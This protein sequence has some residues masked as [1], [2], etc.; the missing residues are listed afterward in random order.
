MSTNFNA[1]TDY[2]TLLECDPD[3]SRDELDI[4]YRN[5]TI[6]YSPG[7]NPGNEAEAQRVFQLIEHA[8]SVLSDERKRSTYNNNRRNNIRDEINDSSNYTRDNTRSYT[9]QNQEENNDFKIYY[10]II[11]A[12][13]IAI[14]I[15]LITRKS[16]N[17]IKDITL[18]NWIDEIDKRGP[19]AIYVVYFCKPHKKLI[20]SYLESD[21]MKNI[22]KVA[23]I[24]ASKGIK[25]GAI[26]R[27]KYAKITEKYTYTQEDT[28]VIFH[29][30]GEYVYDGDY[31][32]S[33]LCDAINEYIPDFSKAADETWN[34]YQN[35]AILFND[36][37]IVP[38][39]WKL[40]SSAFSNSK[41]MIGFTSEQSIIDFYHIQKLPTILI[42][43]KNSMYIYTGEFKYNTIKET[44]SNLY[45]DKKSKNVQLLI[46]QNNGF[47]KITSLKM[48]D[49]RCKGHF[50]YCV[51]SSGSDEPSQIFKDLRNEYQNEDFD[52]FT[53]GKNCPINY[54]NDLKGFWIIHPKRDDAIFVPN[55]NYLRSMIIKTISGN[56]V[57]TPI[58]NIINENL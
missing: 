33:S 50:S 46:K 41:I 47:P 39:E 23:N 7:N 43:H 3:C 13:V 11:I 9:T 54:L 51:I 25:F 1:N 18:N 8:Y 16:G 12:L 31:S 56:V 29:Q 22:T 15:K 37:S 44:I 21:H 10:C 38:P 49:Q 6:K 27:E 4:A 17:Q 32:I 30:K 5:A 28:V 20:K 53:C 36:Y 48:F 58:S 24:L 42:S 34:R 57:F 35:F 52:F 26:D 19:R 55:E 45:N 14:I 40:V 2:Y